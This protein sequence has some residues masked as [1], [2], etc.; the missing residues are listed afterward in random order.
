MGNF[1]ESLQHID[2]DNIID[3][4]IYELDLEKI[5]GYWERC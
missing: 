4:S 1:I 2:K 5:I 3:K